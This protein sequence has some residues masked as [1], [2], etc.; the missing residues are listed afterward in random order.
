MVR[1]WKPAREG[2]PKPSTSNREVGWILPRVLGAWWSR[3]RYYPRCVIWN[4]WINNFENGWTTWELIDFRNQKSEKCILIWM[5]VL[6]YCIMF[7]ILYIRI[8]ILAW[9]IKHIGKPFQDNLPLLFNKFQVPRVI[10]VLEAHG[11]HLYVLFWE[12][13]DVYL[14]M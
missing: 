14:E 2:K 10:P 3:F 6:V 12:H 5:N 9:D 13:I 7:S 8:M 11:C 1:D 4:D